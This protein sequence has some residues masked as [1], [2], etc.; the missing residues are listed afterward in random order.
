MAVKAKGM[1]MYFM[2][3]CILYFLSLFVYF[4]KGIFLKKELLCP[5]EQGHN[6]HPPSRL[7]DSISTPESSA[8][9]ELQVK[10][11]PLGFPSFPQESYAF[12]QPPGEPL[13]Q[14]PGTSAYLNH[15]IAP[16]TGVQLQALHLRNAGAQAPMLT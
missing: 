8:P 13:S 5:L 11:S 15:L 1:V 3:V 4:N 10:I 7:T 9:Q 12:L 6:P 14:S 16:D 2:S